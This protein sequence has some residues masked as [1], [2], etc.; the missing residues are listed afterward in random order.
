MSKA[1][2]HNFTAMLMTILFITGLF[3]PQVAMTKSWGP[4]LAFGTHGE[5]SK[6]PKKQPVQ[7]EEQSQKFE[8]LGGAEGERNHHDHWVGGCW[9]PDNLLSLVLF[10]A[11]QE[12]AAAC[13]N[14]APNPKQPIFLQYCKFLI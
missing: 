6:H 7:N 4:E 14:L 12:S 3:M 10:F 9:N 1:L 11:K 5:N 8:E 13:F 2:R